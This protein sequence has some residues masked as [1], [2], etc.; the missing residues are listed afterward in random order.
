MEASLDHHGDEMFEVY[1]TSGSNG[2]PADD[3]IGRVALHQGYRYFF[4]VNRDDVRS[5]EQARWLACEE[6]ATN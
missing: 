6:A 1:V 5:R 3:L 4:P 2:G